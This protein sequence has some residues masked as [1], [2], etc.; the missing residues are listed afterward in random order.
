MCIVLTST[1]KLVTYYLSVH[2]IDINIEIG[3]LLV[4]C[5]LHWHGGGGVNQHMEISCLVILFL[6]ASL[7]YTPG[8]RD[9]IASNKFIELVM[10]ILKQ[11]LDTSKSWS[12]NAYILLPS[13][14]DR[15]TDKRTKQNLIYFATAKL[16]I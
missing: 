6:Q 8:S 16:C 7:N 2:C 15:Q 14:M 13:G 3:H 1:L 10:E 4:R 12:K 5:A 9:A 11:A